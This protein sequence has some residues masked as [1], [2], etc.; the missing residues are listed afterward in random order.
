MQSPDCEFRISTVDK[1]GNLSTISIAVTTAFVDG[2]NNHGVVPGS[3][4]NNVMQYF[5][6][7]TQARSG[8]LKLAGLN[9]SK[10]YDVAILSS[11]VDVWY[12]SDT[13]LTVQGVAATVNAALVQTES[14][15]RRPRE[16]LQPRCSSS[17]NA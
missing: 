12:P 5:L 9:L 8:A 7:S 3:Y 13:R 16:G 17:K 15:R 11:N 2:T 6:R 1:N 14:A 4:P 10:Q